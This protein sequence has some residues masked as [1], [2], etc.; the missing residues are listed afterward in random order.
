M[1]NRNSKIAVAEVPKLG[2][3]ANAHEVVGT[4]MPERRNPTQAK[5]MPQA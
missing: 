2:Q 5:K 4:S 3:S 1:H